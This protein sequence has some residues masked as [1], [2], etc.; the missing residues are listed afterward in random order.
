MK[1]FI[2]DLDGTIYVDDEM[3]E[4]AADAIHRLKSRGDRVI[5]LT[6]KSIARRTDYVKKLNMLGVDT[7][8]DEVISS[9]FITAKYLKNS[10][11]PGDAA[12]V[13]GEEPLFDELAEENIHIA[14]DPHLA[15]HVVIGWDRKFDYNKLNIAFQAWRN[16]A[17]IIA[18]NP[19]RTCPVKEGELPD[20]GAMIGAIE[21]ATGE[22]VTM[23]IGKPS[24][25]MA[26]YVLDQVLRLPAENVYMVGD[27]LETDIRMGN[28]AGM[29]SV[30]VLTGI[31]D[32]SMLERTV[33]RPKYTLSSVKDID[34]IV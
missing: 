25:L 8:L 22:T 33:D 3:I 4:G 7:T 31:T 14:K 24:H 29:N 6:N 28:E 12:Y 18:T 2:F 27:R 32:S 1:G 9:N 30:L 15:S 16:G 10:M 26:S 20:C 5:F 34:Q 13:I 17:K 21:G 23:I 19:D 11:K